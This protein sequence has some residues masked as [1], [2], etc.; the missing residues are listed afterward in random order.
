MSGGPLELPI[1]YLWRLHEIQIHPVILSAI[2]GEIEG[3]NKRLKSGQALLRLF[4]S[5][6][7]DMYRPQIIGS[8]F[9][10]VFPGEYY[11]PIF[12]KDRIHQIIARLRKWFNQNKIPL[13]IVES[14]GLYQIM[15]SGPVA[16]KFY[17]RELVT[18]LSPELQKIKANFNYD[19][20]SNS[21]AVKLLNI[22]K[23][24]ANR[25]LKDSVEQGVL[26]L[27]GK[28]SATRYKL[29]PSKS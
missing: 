10:K 20:F 28:G 6:T 16:I 13:R 23:S 19:P 5:L 17:N 29:K 24:S 1:E 7:E 14:E 22:S 26:I 11:D 2:S 18:D 27:S 21:D 15:A 12:S 8:V 4:Q 3:Q 9:S 25:L